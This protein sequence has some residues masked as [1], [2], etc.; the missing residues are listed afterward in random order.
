MGLLDDIGGYASD[1]LSGRVAQRGLLDSFGSSSYDP[2]RSFAQ[3]A[4]DPRGIQQATNIGLS[5]GPGAVKTPKLA[6]ID[7]LTAD[8]LAGE[9]GGL[10]AGSPISSFS[11]IQ[12]AQ[13]PAAQTGGTPPGG[14]LSYVLD[15]LR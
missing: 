15:L 7:E 14:L 11:A 6:R 1:A 10:S 5:M 3:N 4:L 12:A 9:H 13:A 2:G 8:R